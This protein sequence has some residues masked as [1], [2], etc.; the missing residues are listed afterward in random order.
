MVSLW[1]VQRVYLED[2]MRRIEEGL[3]AVRPTIDEL[4]LELSTFSRE[5]S[6]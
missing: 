6:S 1:E 4:N 3:L 2:C 5:N